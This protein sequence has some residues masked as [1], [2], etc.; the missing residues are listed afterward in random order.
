MCVFIGL[1]MFTHRSYDAKM[2]KQW[3]TRAGSLYYAS[4]NC[5]GDP[6]PGLIPTVDSTDTGGNQAKADQGAGHL[7]DSERAGLDR[8]WNLVKALPADTVVSG[9]AV[10]DRQT[11]LLSR[12]ISAGSEV[13]CNE[14][15]Y[16]NQWTA[17]FQFVA[18]FARSGG[19]FID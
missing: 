9:S 17:V 16:D 18:G 13:A 1:I 2:D 11:V 8:S 3:G 12:N 19:G 4:H 10:N 6:P 5:E 15:R 14:K 7:R